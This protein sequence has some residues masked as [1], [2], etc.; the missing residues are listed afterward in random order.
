MFVEGHEER[1]L[2]AEYTA[3]SPESAVTIPNAVIDQLLE[4][5]SAASGMG[6]G[7]AWLACPLLVSGRVLEAPYLDSS[8]TRRDYGM[9]DV[10]MILAVCDVLALAIENARDLQMLQVENVRLRA[11]MTP[12]GALIGESAALATLQADIVRVAR[13]RSGGGAAG[14]GVS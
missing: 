12:D 5:R 2:L 11:E 10:P 1:R 13:T 7:T 8:G 4:S 14:C 3:D 6:Q 9:R